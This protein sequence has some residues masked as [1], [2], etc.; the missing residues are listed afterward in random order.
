MSD[1][2]TETV[3]QLRDE[4]GV[5]IMQCKKALEEADGDIEQ[6]RVQLRKKGSEMA[7]KKADRELGAG[8]VAS[9]VHAS[10]D[11]GAL[12]LL[13]S[14]TDF[15]SQNEEFRQLAHDIAMHITAMQPRYTRRS[16]V[17]E[18]DE[19]TARDAFAG[20]VSDK[21]A[22][23]QEQIIQGKLDAYFK[24]QVLNEQPFIKQQDETIGDLLEQATQ[25]FGERIE[26]SQFSIFS[27]R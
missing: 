27:A 22:D 21:P 3:K 6:A 18:A 12:V 9:Y 25:K 14:E 11:I 4:T 16:D 19:Q 2:A 17:P 26:V 15:V 7:Q 23:M 10:G 1:I 13:A 8:A 5:S 24:E 20:E